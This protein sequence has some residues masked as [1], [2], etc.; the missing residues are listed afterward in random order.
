MNEKNSK[1]IKKTEFWKKFWQILEPS[2][3]KFKLLF[4]LIIVYE[5]VSLI[6]PFVLKNIIDRI[7]VFKED[8][9]GFLLILIFLFFISEEFVSLINYFKNR[10]IFKNQFDIDAYLHTR[11]QSKL[12]NLSLSYHEK[13]NTGNKIIKIQNG[14]DKIT[15]LA[16]NLSWEVLPTVIQL[17][18]T[19][20]VLFIVDFRFGLSF[21]FFVP[22]F[23]V[24][25]YKSN[26]KVRP[27][28]KKRYKDYEKAS[29]KMGQA[30][31]NI[32]TVKSF[33]QEERETEEYK[34]LRK[35]IKNQGLKEWFT[36]MK[37]WLVRDLMV[38]LGRVLVL[39][40]AVYLVY[41]GIT[42]LGTL[43]FVI[44]L[45]EKSFFSLYRLSRFYDRVQEAIIAVD[46]FNEMMDEN[47]EIKN[48]KNGIKPK[49]ILG[50]IS[51]KNVNFAYSHSKNKALQGVNLKISAS[52]IT[53]LIGP[54]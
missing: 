24:I 44:T 35:E 11:A 12:V 52:C 9:L 43:V 13:E 39:L 33:V 20:I 30:I 5:L 41:N 51:F 38:D 37:F 4:V 32:N 1:N 16:G 23:L 45:S 46:R 15:E 10:I 29:G 31:I 42:S 2:H 8:D 50:K 40:M 26:V 36:L 53:A 7:G 21:S 19:L 34:N 14:I 49:N 27:W 28:R 22:I 48:P 18:V 25:V 47:I 54:S 3:K 17:I 6:S